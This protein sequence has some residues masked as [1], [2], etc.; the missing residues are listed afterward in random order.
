MRLNFL[1]LRFLIARDP[2]YAAVRDERDAAEFGQQIS[3]VSSSVFSVD[4]AQRWGRLFLII[5]LL[6]S[7]DLQP[8]G[9]RA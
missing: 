3:R 6:M 9:V 1:T 4:L 7:P 2:L 8:E 5:V